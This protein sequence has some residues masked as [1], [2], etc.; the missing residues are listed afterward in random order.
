MGRPTVSIGRDTYCEVQF[1]KAESWSSFVVAPYSSI[2]PDYN[3]LFFV[4]EHKSQLPGNASPLAAAIRT[5]ATVVTAVITTLI[6][7]KSSI[8][9]R[10]HQIFIA[11]M[12]LKSKVR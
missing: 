4:L 11:I 7:S 2:S 1:I 6:L 12:T 5:A 3:P 8:S 9:V 10:S